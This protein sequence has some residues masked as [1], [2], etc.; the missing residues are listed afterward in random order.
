MGWVTGF[1]NRAWETK[2]DL[3]EE[4]TA[5]TNAQRLGLLGPSEVG[6]PRLHSGSKGQRRQEVRSRCC[7]GPC[8]ACRGSVRPLAAGGCLTYIPASDL[9]RNEVSTR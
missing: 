5:R 2:E 9:A 3:L 6:T 8:W 4:G 7:Q 1:V